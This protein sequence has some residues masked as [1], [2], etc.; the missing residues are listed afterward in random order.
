MATY[1]ITGVSRGLGWEFLNQISSNPDNTV[2]GIVRNKTSTDKRVA[3][4]L[5]GRSNITILEADLTTAESSVAVTGGKVDYIIAN[6]GYVPTWDMWDG[7]D[8]LGEKPVEFEEQFTT[9][10]RTNVIGN[11]YLFNSFM[12][13]VLKSKVKKV[14]T[15]S[16]GMGDMD[17]VKDYDISMA[18][19]YAA[20]KAAMNMI[21]AK[22]SAQY[23]E[24][25]VLFLSIC[26]GMVDVG[27]FE[28]VT[29]EQQPALEKTFEK[30]KRYSTTFEGP[31]APP[32]SIKAVLSVINNSSIE[33]GAAGAYLSH[34]GNK[35]W[36]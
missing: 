14:A 33:N 21:A 26:P 2:V 30:F 18:P 25:G 23:K 11:V 32:E 31:D 34:F 3:E 24:H 36:V 10:L 12:P 7:L 27:H 9:L 16:S 4:E 20:S 13:Q 6:A 17:F 5:S 35:R 1:V 22:F 28:T 8:V 19:L 15:I 29:P